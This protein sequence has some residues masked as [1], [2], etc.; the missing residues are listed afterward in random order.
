MWRPLSEVQL[1]RGFEYW[2]Y[3]NSLNLSFEKTNL[4]YNYSEQLS[5]KLFNNQFLIEKKYASLIENKK[6][7]RKILFQLIRLLIIF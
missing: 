6:I 7:Y 2:A 3:R 4:I 1:I 5:M